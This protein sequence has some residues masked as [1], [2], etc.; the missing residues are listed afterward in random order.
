LGGVGV[1]VWK[2]VVLLPPDASSAEVQA[3][4]QRLRGAAWLQ[5]TRGRP[6]VDLPAVVRAVQQVGAWLLAEPRIAEVDVNPLVA[7]PA[8]QGVLALDVLIVL[9]PEHAVAGA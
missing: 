7:Y 3:G 1:E 8:G 2:D 4:L 6:P 5:G 9:Q